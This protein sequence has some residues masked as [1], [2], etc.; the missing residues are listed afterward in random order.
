[1]IVNSQEI[2]SF[3]EVAETKNTGYIPAEYNKY[4]Y[5]TNA[6][7]IKLS[8]LWGPGAESD[9]KEITANIGFVQPP[10]PQAPIAE[11]APITTVAPIMAVV[12][13]PHVV[14]PVVP[15]QPPV[16]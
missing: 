11:V 7:S 15:A 4:I 6:P 5:P 3:L 14:P 8:F 12:G 16:I 2:A 13:V 1:M 9:V 10:A